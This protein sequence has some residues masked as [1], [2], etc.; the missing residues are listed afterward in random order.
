MNNEERRAKMK[1]KKVM[2]PR[3]LEDA[4]LILRGQRSQNSREIRG[5][6]THKTSASLC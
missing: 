3:G 1:M 4:F 2:V 6:D 5:K